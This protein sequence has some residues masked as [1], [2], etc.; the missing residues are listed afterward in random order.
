MPFGKSCSKPCSWWNTTLFL[1]NAA[2]FWPLW[3]VYLA[4]WV[5]ILPVNILNDG[6]RDNF[7]SGV[8]GVSLFFAVVWGVL[9]ATAVFSYLYNGKSVGL[10]HALPLRREGLFLTNYVSG[11]SFMLAPTLLV[12]LLSLLAQSFADPLALTLWLALQVLETLFF[13][14][15]A[16]FCAMFTGNL[17]ALPI[18]YGILNGLA[19]GIYMV[20]STLF[21][22]FAYG[23]AGDLGLWP[24]VDWLTPVLKLGNNIELWRA[25][26]ASCVLINWHIALIYGGVGLLLA[27]AA[28]LLYRRRALEGAG[29]LVTVRPVRPVFKYGV[30]F[31]SAV[32]L[33]AWLY[34][35]LTPAIP[36]GTWSI[37]V[38][39]LLCGALGYFVAE[40]LLRKSFRVFKRSWR[41]AAV[42][43]VLLIAAV[44]GMEFDLLGFNV[45]PDRNQVVRVEL[46]SSSSLPYDSVNRQ[47][48]TFTDPADVNAVMELHRLISSSKAENKAQLADMERSGIT[49][50]PVSS[51]KDRYV[52]TRTSQEFRFIYTMSDGRQIE[53]RYNVP[54]LASG[55]QN[56]DSL[57]S[58]Y[59]ALLNQP[60]TRA[61]AYWGGVPEGARL[62]SASVEYYNSEG[63]DYVSV[64]LDEANQDA[65]LAAVKADMDAGRLGVRFLLETAEYQELASE[66][67]LFF[68]FYLPRA[69]RPDEAAA[70]FTVRVSLQSTAAAALA[71]LEQAAPRPEAAFLSVV[72]EASAV[73]E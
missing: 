68:E 12:Y 46:A 69:Q 16:V 9:C 60:A 42:F 66:D 7:L 36:S 39:L 4:A 27:A 57:E 51:A 2:R 10:M 50:E 8:P 6:W 70:S 1:K 64:S 23:Y 28:L 72:Q 15:F 22:Q 31:C 67:A 48:L 20:L 61:Q 40:M 49:W 38:V 62:V 45:V 18:F 33:G 43:S 24:V 5:L 59:T 34:G 21:S 54:I 56:S 26:D 14:S 58:R 19:T 73:R 17:V 63:G 3:V 44:A 25:E 32:V 29:E 47:S 71:L 41:G 52:Q 11:L 37:L 13:Y 30:A 35:F 65:L 53:R 55:L